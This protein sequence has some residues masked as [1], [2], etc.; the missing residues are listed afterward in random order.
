MKIVFAPAIAP[1]AWAIGESLLPREFR[2]EVLSTEPARR[3]DQLESADFF[4]GF[5]AGLRDSDYDHLK[6]VRLVQVLSAG[7]D[8][9]DVEKLR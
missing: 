3:V 7:Y 9:I 2:I 1:A 8:G 6:H 5:R 4:M